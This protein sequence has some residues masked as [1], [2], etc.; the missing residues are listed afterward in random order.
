ME[1][2]APPPAHP[3]SFSGVPVVRPAR[4]GVGRRLPSIA[5]PIRRMLVYCRRHLNTVLHDNQYIDEDLSTTCASDCPHWCVVIKLSHTF[6]R[7]GL[8]A[9][10]YKDLPST[11]VVYVWKMTMTFTVLMSVNDNHLFLVTTLSDIPQ[12]MSG[13]SSKTVL[14]KDTRTVFF[15]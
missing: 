14:S 11:A 4:P 5:S 8:H 12:I 10:S 9:T 1:S 13:S 3:V 2:P 6:K 15:N 7:C